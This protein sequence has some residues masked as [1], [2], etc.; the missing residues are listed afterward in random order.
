MEVL[1][2]LGTFSKVTQLES[3]KAELNLGILEP[4]WSVFL[5]QFS[6]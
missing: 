1:E 2:K 5:D 6:K 4:R 3:S